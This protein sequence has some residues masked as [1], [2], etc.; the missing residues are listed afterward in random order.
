MKM[1]DYYF[2][3][4]IIVIIIIINNFVHAGVP[5]ILKCGKALNERKTEVRVQFQ[6]PP[7][8]LFNVFF[9]S[10]YFFSFLPFLL[11]LML[12][13]GYSSQRIGY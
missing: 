8:H 10:F 7:Y 1:I 11:I 6:A 12:T 5:F 4:I 9:L 3:I 2:T 13:I